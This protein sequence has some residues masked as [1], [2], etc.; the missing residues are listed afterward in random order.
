MSKNAQNIGGA[1]T[2]M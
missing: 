2:V 1:S